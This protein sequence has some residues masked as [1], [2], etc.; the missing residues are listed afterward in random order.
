MKRYRVLL[1]LT[2]HTADGSYTQGE[3][4]GKAFTEEEEAAN[5]DSGLL[6]I[7]PCEYRVM[8]GS[9]VFAT[10]PGDVFLA[11]MRIGQ[12]Q[13]LIAGGHIERVEAP[14]KGKS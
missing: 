14:K 5:L 1:P 10:R 7:V 11:P 6:E 2:V 8:G 12:E 13:L 3:E 4:F 9:E